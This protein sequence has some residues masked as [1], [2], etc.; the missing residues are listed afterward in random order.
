[1]ALLTLYMDEALHYPQ[2]TSAQIYG[3]FIF[4]VYFLP[5]FGG[6]IADHW[7]GFYRTVLIGAVIMGFGQLALAAGTEATF[8][9]ALGLVAFGTGLLKPNISTIVGGLYTD[10]P[11]LRDSGF[12]IFYMGINIGAFIAPIVVAWLRAQYGWGA[13]FASAA[14][15]MIA[16]V[17]VFTGFKRYLPA[18]TAK[19]ATAT[20][21][22]AAATADER[23]RILGLLVVFA[24]VIAFWVA[25]YQNGFTLTLWARD[26]TDTTVS[27]EV[28]QSVNPLGII[29]FSPLLVA[30]WAALRRRGVEPSTLNKIVI[31]MLLTAISFGIMAAAGLDGGDTGKVSASW[32]VSSYLVIAL[33]E[34]CLSPMGLSLV[35]KVAPPRHRATMMGAWFGATAAGGY[36]SG[37]VGRYWN[38]LPH[39]RF[40]LMVVGLCLV[41]AVLMALVRSRLG[42]V[43]STSSA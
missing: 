29:L 28:F 34:I 40:F 2:T 31:G 30:G 33:A 5:L 42:K 27:P 25:F 11:H 12:N 10:R 22:V 4:A 13:A 35:T 41:A 3:L 36:L 24:V 20:G 37:F 17:A 43:F 6:L 16:A 15:A 18:A 21:P 23:A 38:T 9:I 39:S 8:L 1:M 14:I 26:N 7:L 32:L 19:Q